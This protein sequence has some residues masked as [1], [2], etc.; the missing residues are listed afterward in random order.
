VIL[1][2]NFPAA[3]R[4]FPPSDD[5]FRTLFLFLS[6]PFQSPGLVIDY[7]VVALGGVYVGESPVQAVGIIGAGEG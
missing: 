6:K 1:G 4:L 5:S 2:F 7:S 3:R